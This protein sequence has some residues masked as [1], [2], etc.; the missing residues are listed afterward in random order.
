[1]SV[2]VA[3]KLA[4]TNPDVHLPN[5]AKSL[6]N[7]SFD[8]GKMDRHDDA[9]VAMKE[10][11]SIYRR[12]VSANPAAHLPHLATSL[13]NLADI[14]GELGRQQEAAATAEE[15]VRVRTERRQSM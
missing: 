7:L 9:I 6:N 12:L 15:A 11:V 1:M 3:R 13:D 4:A 5:L 14:L 8:L 2:S 10:V